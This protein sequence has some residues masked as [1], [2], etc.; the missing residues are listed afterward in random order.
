MSFI[1]KL[2]SFLLFT[3]S[4]LAQGTQINPVTQIRWPVATGSGAPTSPTWPCT[5]TQ[6]GMPYTDTAANQQYTCSASGWVKGGSGISGMTA[7]QVPIAGT[8]ST[9]TSSKPLGGTAAAIPTI[10]NSGL[11]SGDIVTL[12]GTTGQLQ[13]GGAPISG[14]I[15]RSPIEN[16]AIQIPYITNDTGGSFMIQTTTPDTSTSVRGSASTTFADPTT[17]NGVPGQGTYSVAQYGEENI[18]QGGDP[19]NNYIQHFD[20]FGYYG[21]GWNSN[22]GGGQWSTFNQHAERF[23]VTGRGI[24]QQQSIVCNFTAVGDKACPAYVYDDNFGGFYTVNDEGITPLAIQSSQQGYLTSTITAIGADGSRATGTLLTSNSITCQTPSVG[25]G[26]AY[27]WNDG[28]LLFDASNPTKQGLTISGVTQSYTGNVTSVG[29]DVATVTGGTVTASTA[30]GTAT[31]CTS[32]ESISSQ[33]YFSNTCTVTLGTSGYFVP[34]T[35]AATAAGINGQAVGF[36]EQITITSAS[37]CSSCTSQTVTFLTRHDWSEVNSGNV[38]VLMQGGPVGNVIVTGTYPGASQSAW[39]SSLWPMAWMVIGAYDSTHLAFGACVH[40]ECAFNGANLPSGAITLYPAAEII[41]TN[42]KSQ[43]QAQLATNNNPWNVGD[44]IIG[45]PVTDYQVTGFKIYVSQGTPTNGSF[46]SGGLTVADLSQGGLGYLVSLSQGGN[47][48]D[49]APTQ[50]AAYALDINVNA[51]QFLNFHYPP[52]N[53]GAIINIEDH[54]LPAAFTGTYSLLND[55]RGPFISVTRQPAGQ[56]WPQITTNAGFNST[57]TLGANNLQNFGSSFPCLSS[58]SDGTIVGPCKPIGPN[59][60]VQ[61]NNSGAVFGSQYTTISPDT[62]GSGTTTM[63]FSQSQDLGAIQIQA[64]FNDTN[65]ITLVSSD[66]I[67]VVKLDEDNQDSGRITVIGGGGRVQLG[68]LEGNP[69]S[70]LASSLAGSGAGYITLASNGTGDIIQGPS[71]LPP[72][73]EASG[74]L[75]GSYPSPTVAAVHATSGTMDGVTIGGTTPPVNPHFA[76]SLSIGAASIYGTYMAVSNSSS[77]AAWAMQVLGSNFSLHPQS[78]G[79]YNGTSNLVSYV[80]GDDGLTAMKTSVLGWANN[81]SGSGDAGSNARDTGFSRIGAG[82]V[83]VG[84]GT[85]GD[86][87][88]SLTAAGVT[89]TSYQETLTTPASSS[90]TCTAG[91]FTDD[92]NYHYVCVATNT[93]KRAALSSF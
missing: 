3:G 75:S 25:C 86:T 34:T 27:F 93:W 30:W 20:D 73:G 15:L 91:Q 88:G 74:D 48:N 79:L 57:Q 49:T 6:Y 58:L 65:S 12:N 39:N 23:T 44:T 31:S 17:F 83:A 71:S 37:S 24:A 26:N 5:S 80:F 41:G 66:G 2:L 59:G 40:G 43:V 70:I 60:A 56:A 77:G 87:S 69:G 19:F 8:A 47:Y 61:Y 64:G 35:N 42:G 33:Q 63:S 16:Q 13:D 90:A 62:P 29:A 78:F 21:Q 22:S 18:T 55:S 67:P 7:G 51:N 89:A 38:V 50:T 11:T 36:P 72:N 92:T 4:V 84:N 1:S 81:S 45:A 85:D 54:T 28:G 10:P 32:T 9:I 46:Q 76:D 82:S 68:N 53:N 14:I 52:V